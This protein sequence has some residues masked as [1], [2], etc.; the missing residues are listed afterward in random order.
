MGALTDSEWSP[1]LGV[2]GLVFASLIAGPYVVWVRGAFG[3]AYQS[4]LR[5]PPERPEDL[6][7]LYRY[8][9]GDTTFQAMAGAG[10]A[11]L[12]T[13]L[14][15]LEQPWWVFL[16]AWIIA[17]ARS[18]WMRE[19]IRVDGGLSRPRNSVEQFLLWTAL[20]ATVLMDLTIVASTTW[21]MAN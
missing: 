9:A 18:I 20:G 10:A 11:V 13:Q 17:L 2:L 14:L 12:S 16:A 8:D 3:I 15:W 19:R 5:W 1:L 4:S 7:R 6:D 21:N